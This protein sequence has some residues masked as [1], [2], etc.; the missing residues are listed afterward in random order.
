LSSSELAGNLPA[1]LN[2]RPYRAGT[3][4][5]FITWDEGS[6]GYSL[7]DCDDTGVT[8]ASCRVPTIVISPTT[9]A[10]ARSTAFFSHY[11][12]L[13]T[14]EQLLGLPRLGQAASAPLMTA[15]FRL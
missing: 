4:A 9:P 13:A 7:E 14:T 3:T 15:P 8:D 5:V 2:G 10:G 11:S 6:G 12:L 1:I